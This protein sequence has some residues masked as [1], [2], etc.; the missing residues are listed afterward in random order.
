MDKRR[1]ILLCTKILE[2]RRRR[3]ATQ[4]A[5]LT[6]IIQRRIYLMKLYKLLLAVLYFFEWNREIE[7]IPRPRSA[8]RFQRNEGWWKLVWETYSEDRFKK[9]FRVTKNTFLFILDRIYNVLKKESIKEDAIPP[10]C[11]LG[12]C[13]YRLGRG[14]YYYTIA[15][16]AGLGEATICLIVIEV[17][18]VIVNVF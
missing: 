18:Q 8:R 7:N 16:M 9:L 1:K 13:L 15:E 5:V 11:R 6:N 10:E 12:V 17:C 3:H 4:F 2:N 14:D